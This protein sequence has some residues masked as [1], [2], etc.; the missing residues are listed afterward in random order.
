MADS[1]HR[2]VPIATLFAI[3]PHQFPQGNNQPPS[4]KWVRVGA[5][6]AARQGRNLVGNF[7]AVP[8]NWMHG[9]CEQRVCV[10]YADERKGK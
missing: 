2:D 8:W 3:V 9:N 7:D 5:L 1:S 10:V 6:W 4:D